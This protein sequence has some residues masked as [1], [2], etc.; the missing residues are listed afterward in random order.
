M[1]IH[2]E[3][4]IRKLKCSLAMMKKYSSL[5]Y[6]RCLFASF[7]KVSPRG[8]LFGYISRFSIFVVHILQQLHLISA[9]FYQFDLISSFLSFGF[10][11]T[12]LLIEFCQFDFLRSISSVRFIQ[13]SIIIINK[14]LQVLLFQYSTF[15][16]QSKCRC[17]SLHTRLSVLAVLELQETEQTLVLIYVG[18]CLNTFYEHV[19]F[20][21]LYTSFSIRFDND[22]L[23]PSSVDCRKLSTPWC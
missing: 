9:G 7:S 17:A 12:I 18:I 2:H 22:L 13:I 4:T 21:E 20:R 3:E 11:S 15:I 8:G 14:S 23:S 1:Q 16:D 19:K 6:C 10:L 5:L